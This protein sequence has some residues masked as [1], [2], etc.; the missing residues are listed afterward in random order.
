LAVQKFSPINWTA[1][2][3]LAL[4]LLPAQRLAIEY[5]PWFAGV[6]L[7][8]FAI[9]SYLFTQLIF[10]N[11]TFPNA[12]IYPYPSFNTFYAGRWFA[13]IVILLGGRSG[14]QALEFAVASAIQVGNAFIF[15]SLLGVRK[16]WLILLFG[17]FL[18]LHPAFLDYYSFHVDHISF[19]LGD[20]LAL[21]GVVTL[22]KIDRLRISVPLAIACFVLSLAIHQPKVALIA[23]LLLIWLLETAQKETPARTARNV[24]IA[25]VVYLVALAIYYLS[26]KMTVSVEGFRNEINSSAEVLHQLQATYVQTYLNFTSRVDYLPAHLQ[27]LPAACIVAGFISI[28]VYSSAVSASSALISIGLLLAIPVALQFSYVINDQTWTNSGRILTSHAYVLLFLIACGLRLGLLRPVV[29]C[30]S[31]GLIYFF[32]VVAAQETNA[33]AFKN[34]FDV[35]KVNRIVSRIETVVPDLYSGKRFQLIIAG[36]LPF[37]PQR[38][39][40]YKNSLYKSQFSTETLIAYRHVEII[41]FFLGRE[42]VRQPDRSAIA[43]FEASAP[44]R[45]PWPATE[46]VYVIGDDIIAILLQPYSK[47]IP[48]TWDETRDE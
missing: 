45:L 20:T 9:Y 33:A 22:S 25:A 36:E 19:V 14:A 26:A 3:R 35:A 2:R 6:Y 23:T 4:W 44:F 46:S 18:A 31:I 7:I 13:D 47:E 42:V 8:T 37:E 27:L 30:M 21:V 10:T 24:L 16:S 29:L 12:W 32:G 1:H 28:L 41:N 15:A 40:R 5:A 38:F 34:I 11:H 39:K 17:L 43:Q 48:I